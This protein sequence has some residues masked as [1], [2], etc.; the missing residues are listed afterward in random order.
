MSSKLEITNNELDLFS[1]I[2]WRLRK[3]ESNHE[4]MRQQILIDITRLLKSD[5]GASHIYDCHQERS[6]KGISINIDSK[7]IQEYESHLYI[8][9]FVTRKMREHRK[10]ACVDNL[11]DRK[12]L[13][14]SEHYNEFLKPC[15]M[16]HGMNVFFVS[17][18]HDIGDLRI[19]R[20]ADQPP[21]D[22]KDLML[23]NALTPYFEESLSAISPRPTK[24]TQREISVV[25]HVAKG[26]SDKEI[27]RLMGIEFTTVRT[28]LKNAMHKTGASNRTDLAI[29]G[30]MR[31]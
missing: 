29:R 26:C 3:S 1:E 7:M 6:T 21:F 31:C 20:S 30:L 28:H 23:I 24:L 16:H 18:N 12:I 2:I 15:G 13:E 19:W 11:I 14:V 17:Q 22:I 5:F 25:E 4:N 10:A 8:S 27:A 9:D